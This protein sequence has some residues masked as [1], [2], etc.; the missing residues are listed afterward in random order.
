M[1]DNTEVLNSI[2]EARE[3]LEHAQ[4]HAER[5]GLNPLEDVPS[6]PGKST[7]SK[8]KF[9]VKV[10]ARGGLSRI[11]SEAKQCAIYFTT[12]SAFAITPL[13]LIPGL[14]IAC[15]HQSA[16]QLLTI[17]TSGTHPTKSSRSLNATQG[18]EAGYIYKIYLWYY[19]VSG[20]AVEAGTIFNETDSCH[21]TKQG[22]A[23]LLYLCLLYPSY[24]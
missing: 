5:E 21:Q 8:N 20:V 3:D 7:D 19:C 18:G 12:L 9:N 23:S 4:E 2:K 10:V 24:N 13:L 17:E 15:Y 16:L 14:I 22:K 11:W 1:A 6:S